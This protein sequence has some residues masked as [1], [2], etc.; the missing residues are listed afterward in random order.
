MS[1]SSPLRTVQKSHSSVELPLATALFFLAV[2]GCSGLG[3]EGSGAGDETGGAASGGFGTG[4]E[5]SGGS[6][7]GGDG[8]GATGGGGTGGQGSGG[9]GSGGSAAGGSG[10]GG[11]GTG[12]APPSS[13][14]PDG[15][16]RNP[17]VTQIF[18][19]DPNAIVY[20]D[21]VYLYVS[22]DEDGQDGF[23]MI[24]HHVYSSDDLANWEDHGVT[25]DVDD[26]SWAGRLF[27]PGACEKNGQY[28][29]Y[30]TNGGSQIGVAVSD[31]PEGP[32]TDALGHG[33][34]SGSF[35]NADV[36]WLFDPA[37]YVDD[38]GQAYLYFGGGPDGGQNAR[39]VRLGDDMV[40]IADAA[41]TTVPTT[42]FFEAS[43]MHKHD[44][45]YYFSYSSDFSNGHGAALEY[46]M[47]DSPMMQNSEY[48][49]IFLRNSGINNGN[50]N[51]G[52]IVEFQGK[53]YLFYHNRK[54]MQQLGTNK[55]NNRSIAVQELTYAEDG[56]II[57]LDM[58]TDDTTV[59]QLKCLD[60]FSEVEAERLAAES[61][62]EV[63]GDTGETVRV[64]QID[65]GDWVAYSQVDFQD[66]ASALVLRIA[67]ASGGATIDV[68]Q[69]GCLDGDAGSVVGTCSVESTG[70]LETF[71]ELTCTIS[72][73]AGAHDLCLK[74]SGDTDFE[75]DSFHLE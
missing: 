64:A 42:A 49:G 15:A 19:A 62:I 74:F 52:S 3:G 4:G 55:V 31:S 47:G 1:S 6:A 36:P 7:S 48:K 13:C 23:D 8:G 54:L 34:L 26:L 14:V 21:R 46:Y 40:S 5:S 60:A 41:A 73:P 66:G 25:I 30:L 10:A 69:D 24:D 67:A 11:Q 56:T 63:E 29:M 59:R 61:G 51:H 70:G 45:K 72:A 22:H 53:T 68:V 32:F 35:P 18:T 12:G 71:A 20:G 58:S 75:L 50:N 16:A 38:D 43:F 9:V 39:V 17:L 44:G 27:A 2:G 33:L 28:Y 57:P 65:A 37:C